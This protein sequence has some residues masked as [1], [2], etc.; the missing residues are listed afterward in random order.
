MRTPSNLS[1]L[2]CAHTLSKE[3]M[4]WHQMKLFLKVQL[5]LPQSYLNLKQ[6]WTIWLIKV[7]KSN[8][9]SSLEEIDPF[10][11]SS[12]IV[13]TQPCILPLMLIMPWRRRLRERMKMRLISVSMQSS[14]SLDV[15]IH[16]ISSWATISQNSPKDF[17]I[18]LINPKKLR[19]KCLTSSRSSMV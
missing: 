9:N 10:R 3:E 17:L 15:F 7:S 6:K 8:F 2:R 14:T 16:V 11:P 1:S 13:H 4:L 5:T 19:S 18:N 12:T